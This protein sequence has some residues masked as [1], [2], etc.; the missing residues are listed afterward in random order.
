ME[1][2]EDAVV[3]GVVLEVVVKVAVAEQAED[4]EVAID[5]N[6]A[7]GKPTAERRATLKKPTAERRATLRTEVGVTDADV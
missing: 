4:V 6:V 3:A 7:R 2:A 5:A 1:P